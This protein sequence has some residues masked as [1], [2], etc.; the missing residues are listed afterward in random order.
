MQQTGVISDYVDRLASELKFDR[1]LSRCV[2]QEIE[3]HLWKPSRP[4]RCDMMEAQR[5]AIADSGTCV[6]SPPS[7][8][9]YRSRRQQKSGVAA[10]VV[11]A[12]VFVAMKTRLDGMRRCNGQCGRT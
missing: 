2:R 3:D 6:S 7:S 8:P 11:I 5:R 1:S 10:I 4:I 12:G 9:S